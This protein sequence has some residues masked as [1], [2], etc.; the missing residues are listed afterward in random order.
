MR[1]EKF[2]GRYRKSVCGGGKESLR[3]VASSK[4]EIFRLWGASGGPF[5]SL[6]LSAGF[7]CGDPGLGASVPILPFPTHLEAQLTPTGSPGPASF[8][9]SCSTMSARVAFLEIGGQKDP[10]ELRCLLPGTSLA[11]WSSLY[12][13]APDARPLSAYA[14]ASQML[15]ALDTTQVLRPWLPNENLFPL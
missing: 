10:M 15:L 14:A 2:Q 3:S 9:C 6:S 12:F 7:R 13:L 5:H 4:G 8:S 1:L 11:G